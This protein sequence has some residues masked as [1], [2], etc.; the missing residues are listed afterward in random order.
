MD[1]FQFWIEVTLSILLLITIFYSLYLGRALAVIRRDRNELNALISSL[2]ASSQQAHAGIDHL[3]QTTEL[4][5]R[6]LG[7]TVDSGRQLQRELAQLCDRSESLAEKLEDSLASGRP[8]SIGG[9]SGVA[10]AGAFRSVSR[11]DREEG[12]PVSAGPS[13]LGVGKSAA[14]RELLRALR[15]KQG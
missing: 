11:L 7:K 4:V 12:A 15:Q 10:D 14:E 5:G 13:T 9:R 2:Q 3:R 6:A 1:R 8:A